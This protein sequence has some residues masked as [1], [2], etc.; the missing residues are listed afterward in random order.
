M[1]IQV[2]NLHHQPSLSFT[3]FLEKQ[4]QALGTLR[5]IDEARVRLEHH[6]ESSPPF[7]VAL[8]LVTPGPD[9]AAEAVDHTLRAALAKVVGELEVKIKGRT[10][11]RSPRARGNLQ[12]PAALQPGSKPAA[13]R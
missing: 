11:N 4:L 10:A 8:H 3:S 6:A 2:R 13:R 9:F 7:R 12:E 1:K 5:Q